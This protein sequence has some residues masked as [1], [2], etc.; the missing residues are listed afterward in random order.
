M[1]KKSLIAVL[2]LVF[3]M[4][5]ALCGCEDS[6]WQSDYLMEGGTDTVLDNEI[7][8]DYDMFD[9]VKEYEI[10]VP[11]DT[12]AHI[13]EI[14]NQ[15]SLVLTVVAEGQEPV[16]SQDVAGIINCDFD[17]P[18]GNYTV[19]VEAGDHSGRFALTW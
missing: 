10:T 2:L 14:T 11:A 17:L 16:F 19:K 18:A 1:K 15:G 12:T 5:F 7:S 9:G 4:G 13:E 8:A 6:G 3:C